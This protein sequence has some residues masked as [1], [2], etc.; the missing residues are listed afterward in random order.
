[1]MMMSAKAAAEGAAPHHHQSPAIKM[2]KMEP[3]WN[4]KG[5]SP[6]SMIGTKQQH[7]QYPGAYSQN[8]RLQPNASLSPLKSG[9]ANN[10]PGYRT[11]INNRP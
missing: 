9:H 8:Q 1:M 5:G 2:K 10:Q 7:L 6:V 4:D 3:S 11:Q